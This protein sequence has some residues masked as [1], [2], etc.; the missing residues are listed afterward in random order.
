M[1]WMVV[2]IIGPESKMIFAA[3]VMTVLQFTATPI[4]VFCCD[5]HSLRSYSAPTVRTTTNNLLVRAFMW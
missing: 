1:K 3:K 5:F 2:I 4:Q